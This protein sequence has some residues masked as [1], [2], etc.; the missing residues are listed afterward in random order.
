[1][2]RARN[3]KPGLYKNEDLAECSIWARFIFPGLW[4]LADREGRLEDRPKRIKGELTP[5]DSIDIEPLL[6][7]LAHWKFIRRY[8]INGIRCI[9]ITNFLVHQTPHG[10]EKDSALP[11]ENGF[12]II[13]E[14]GKNSCITGKFESKKSNSCD[15]TVNPPLDNVVPPLATVNPPSDNT[16][17]PESL[18]ID[19]LNPST[20]NPDSKTHTAASGDFVGDKTSVCV[21]SDQPIFDEA[22]DVLPPAAGQPADEPPGDALQVVPSMT[23]AVCMAMRAAGMAS[24]SPSHADLPVLLANGAD[25]GMFV[26]AART[27]I[28]KQKGFSYA[29]GIVKGQLGAAKNLADQIGQMPTPPPRNAHKYAAAHAAIFD[30]QP[31]DF[32]DV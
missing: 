7:E 15:S 31:R 30:D 16:L 8:E 29:V 5:F 13:H 32:I 2:A 10:T 14:R 12:F 28:E 11:D 22:G 9:Q 25:I 27:A 18:F 19:S 20:L 21:S 26:A 1:M 3:I 4:M 6:V 17:N 24:V 23:A